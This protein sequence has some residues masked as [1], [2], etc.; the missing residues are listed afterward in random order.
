MIRKFLS[1]PVGSSLQVRSGLVE[2][3]EKANED[4][5]VVAVVVCGKNQFIAGAD[6]KEFSTGDYYVCECLSNFNNFVNLQVMLFF[7]TAR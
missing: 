5:N 4:R 6:I 3:V 1:L 2:G 7:C